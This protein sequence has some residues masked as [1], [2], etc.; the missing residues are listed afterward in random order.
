MDDTLLPGRREM[1]AAIQNFYDRSMAKISPKSQRDRVEK[2]VAAGLISQTGRRL[3]LAGSD[4][5]HRFQVEAATLQELVD[6]RLLRSDYRLHELYYELSH[7]T[8][9]QPIREATRRRV[10][11]KRRLTALAGLAAMV[12][13]GV[14]VLFTVV[15][16]FW[17]QEE[18]QNLE[19]QNA[20]AL[21]SRAALLRDKGDY[22]QAL[23]LYREALAIR[24]RVLGPEH[25]D[26]ATSLDG[27]GS[28]YRRRRLTIRPC[29]VPAGVAIR[30]SWGR[31]SRY[32]RQP[33]RPRVNLSGQGAYEQALPLFQRALA[34]R[35]KA[36]GMEHP[37]G[38]QLQRTG[39]LYRAGEIW[40]GGAAVSAG[41]G[42]RGKGPGAGAPVYGYQPQLLAN[43]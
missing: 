41:A 33:Q 17:F 37:D 19:L 35:E 27:L 12:G 9:I 28:I 26:T 43:I 24:E 7:D 23:D 42:D 30:R 4:I 32:R 39:G 31:A 18:A 8:L 21:F 11:R 38:H 22:E 3:S 36:L 15:V 16:P 34:I 14:Y 10:R 29:P 1:R 25:P 13:I 40:P 20:T 6:I 2:M 5:Q